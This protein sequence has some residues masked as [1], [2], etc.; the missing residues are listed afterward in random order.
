MPAGIETYGPNGAVLTSY[1]S[2]I[3]RQ[4]GQVATG[5]SNGSHT[6]GRLAEGG[7]PWLATLPQG[8]P[9]SVNAPFVWFDGITIRWQFLDGMPGERATATIIYGT[10]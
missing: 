2:K 4:F 1:L 8:N 9:A 6:D 7:V 3:A 5:T 10:R